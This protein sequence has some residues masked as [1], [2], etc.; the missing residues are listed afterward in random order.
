MSIKSHIL[1]HLSG[2]KTNPQSW[3]DLSNTEKITAKKIAGLYLTTA[4]GLVASLSVAFHEIKNTPHGC[5]SV[6]FP[7]QTFIKQPNHCKQS[8]YGLGFGTSATLTP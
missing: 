3:K 5:T 1:E 8:I 4:F 2:S 7:E 6:V